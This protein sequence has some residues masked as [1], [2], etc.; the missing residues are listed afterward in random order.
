M[1]I[2]TI[3]IMLLLLMAL[4]GC[5]N[6]TAGSNG[7]NGPASQESCAQGSDCDQDQDRERTRDQDDDVD[8]DRDRDRD[9]DRDEA[10]GVGRR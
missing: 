6:S 1:R 2:T 9:R 3:T 5:V 8:Q 10:G 4:G 7:Q